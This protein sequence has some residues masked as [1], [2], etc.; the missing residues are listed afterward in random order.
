MEDALG[1]PDDDW[2]ESVLAVVVRRPA[3]QLSEAEVVDYVRNRLAGFKKP[4]AVWFVDHLPRTA[5]TRQ[6]QKTLLRE[7]FLQRAAQ[8]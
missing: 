1:I 4:R 2:G 3:H 6:V 5:A 8:K 7:Q